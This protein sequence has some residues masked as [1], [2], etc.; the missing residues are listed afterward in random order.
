MSGAAL[1]GAR[2]LRDLCGRERLQLTACRRSHETLFAAYSA[3][4]HLLP[5]MPLEQLLARYRELFPPRKNPAS[6]TWS[7]RTCCGRA[8]A[9][10]RGRT[11]A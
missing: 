4:P 2:Y 9:T 8:P 7:S 6:T 11:G 3:L 10:T 5:Q 1:W